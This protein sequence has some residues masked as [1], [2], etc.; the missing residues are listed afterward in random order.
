MLFSATDLSR[1]VN[2]AAAAWRKENRKKEG[3]RQKKKKG[4]NHDD[5]A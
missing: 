2:V 1:N 5:S 3:E 4:P